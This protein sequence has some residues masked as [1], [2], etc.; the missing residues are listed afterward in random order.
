MYNYDP[1]DPLAA[2]P[3]DPLRTNTD[4]FAESATAVLDRIEQIGAQHGCQ[5]ANW[6][7]HSDYDYDVRKPAPRLPILSGFVSGKRPAAARQ[8]VQQWAN[9]L[10]L[11]PA[12]KPN[13]GT[14][15]FAG[16]IEGL[17]VEVWTVVDRAAFDGKL[18]TL[19]MYG[20]EVLL[21]ALVAFSSITAGVL[22]ARHKKLTATVK[23]LSR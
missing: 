21:T 2:W 23:A 19:T 7:W 10:G 14:L 18:S 8:A 20:P 22:L 13:S 4:K 17:K 9:A 6:S 12:R 16:E 3:A 1:Q 11:T 15:A 5:P